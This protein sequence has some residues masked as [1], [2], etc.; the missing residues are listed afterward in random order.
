M[1][2][3]QRDHFLVAFVKELTQDP[4]G[5]QVKIL[6]LFSFPDDHGPAWK[7]S[8]LK[9]SRKRGKLLIGELNVLS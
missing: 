9:L 7:L 1:A 2:T 4:M 3:W 5:Y 6:F 8:H